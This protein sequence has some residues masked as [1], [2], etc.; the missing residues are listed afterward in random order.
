MVR[1]GLALLAVVACTGLVAAAPAAALV[2]T[3]E[4]H[5]TSYDVVLTVND[6]GTLDARETID[7]DFGSAVGKHGIF[8][9]FPVRVPYD[10]KNDRVYDVENFRV[11]SPTGAPTDV[12]D[13]ESG[14]TATYR[15]GDPDRTVSGRERYVITYRVDGA[16]NAFPDHVELYWNAIGDG[17]G[18]PIAAATVRVLTPTAPTQQACFAGPTGSSLPCGSITAAGTEVTA[19]QSDGLFAYSAFTVVVGL[20]TG[21]VTATGPLLE[22]RWT[23]RQSL[24]PTPLTGSLAGLLLIPGLAGIAWLVG[25]RGRDRR[26]AGQTPGLVLPSGGVDERVPPVSFSSRQSREENQCARSSSTMRR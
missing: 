6:D 13:S 19:S 5:I 7:Y 10:D 24:T 22:E 8:R 2:G 12:D 17:W 18:V 9:T 4:E 1:R 3:G 23:L 20:P 14:G 25:V 21:A 15:I 16:L 11:E 26:Y